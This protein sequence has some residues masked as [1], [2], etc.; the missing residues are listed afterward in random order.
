VENPRKALVG[1]EIKAPEPM[2]I[3]PLKKKRL[4]GSVEAIRKIFG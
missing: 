4:F 1:E 3:Q 2:P